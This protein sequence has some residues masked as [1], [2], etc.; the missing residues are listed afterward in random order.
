MEDASCQQQLVV[1][2]NTDRITTTPAC[3][4]LIANLVAKFPPIP[5]TIDAR[6]TR[7]SAARLPLSKYESYYENRTANRHRNQKLCGRKLE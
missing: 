2:N 6:T 3:L 1:P 5:D 4:R 7:S